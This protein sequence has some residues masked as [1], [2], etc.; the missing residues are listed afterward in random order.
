MAE[1]KCGMTPWGRVM[2]FPSMCYHTQQKINHWWHH[3]KKTGFSLCIHSLVIWQNEPF[4]CTWIANGKTCHFPKN[5]HISQWSFGFFLATHQ[6]TWLCCFVFLSSMSR[7]MWKMEMQL[8]SVIN[9]PSTNC[10]LMHLQFLL[11]RMN[12]RCSKNW[13]PD[14]VSESKLVHEINDRDLLGLSRWQNKHFLPLPGMQSVKWR[15]F[16]YWNGNALF[17]LGEKWE[18]RESWATK[19]QKQLPWLLEMGGGQKMKVT[20]NNDQKRKQR[21]SCSKLPLEWPE[22]QKLKIAGKTATKRKRTIKKQWWWLQWKALSL[23]FLRLQ[24]SC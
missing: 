13:L 16:G 8:E 23:P 17:L 2:L 10:H 18:D 4:V 3:H 9:C 6:G 24:S 14:S 11:L 5:T 19:V 1:K 12:A 21:T 22:S 20:Q 15:H 7:E